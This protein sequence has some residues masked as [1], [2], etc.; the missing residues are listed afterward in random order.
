MESSNGSSGTGLQ[1]P[2]GLVWV[3][4]GTKL[5]AAVAVVDRGMWAVVEKGIEAGPATVI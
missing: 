4:A 1:T 5:E 2:I 3:G